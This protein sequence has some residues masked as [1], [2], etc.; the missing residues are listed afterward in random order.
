MEGVAAGGIADYSNPSAGTGGMQ[1]LLMESWWIPG[2]IIEVAGWRT[3]V[4]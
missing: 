1:L 4:S 2:N 3:G